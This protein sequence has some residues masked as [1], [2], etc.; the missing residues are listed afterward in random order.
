MLN[1]KIYLS[2]CFEFLN[3]VDDDS[4]DLAVI[5]PPYNFA[6]DTWDKFQS[7]EQFFEFT[8]GWIDKLLPKLKDSGSIYIFNSPHHCAYIAKYLDEKGMIFRNWI[9]W[10]KRDGFSATKTKF[11]PTQETILFYSKSNDYVFNAD[12]VRI[13]YESTQRMTHAAKAGILKNGKRWYPNPLGK[14]CN[15]VWHIVSER[16][17]LKENGKV[18]KLGHLTPKPLEIIERI[19]LASSKKGDLVLDCFMGSGTTAVA[20]IKNERNFIGCDSSPVY[21]KAAE[22]RVLK[23][24]NI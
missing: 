9:T 21:V 1:N 5:D 3:K 4:I 10:D 7:E 17:K 16:H 19:I 23:Y 2:D 13:P 22:E 15:D 20:A 12:A 6:K 11:N 18:M 24:G 14:L 8:Y